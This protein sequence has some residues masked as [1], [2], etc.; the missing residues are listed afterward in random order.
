MKDNVV[1]FPKA[2]KDGTP[3]QSLEEIQNHIGKNR[4]KYLQAIAG[5]ISIDVFMKLEQVG[6]DY[7]GDENLKKDFTLINE[8]IKSALG[9][10]LNVQHP[11]QEFAEHSIDTTNSE[12]DYMLGELEEMDE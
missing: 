11:L 10:T 6:V 12:I 9:R 4:I 3:P 8:A 7:Q 1:I 5:E 2:K